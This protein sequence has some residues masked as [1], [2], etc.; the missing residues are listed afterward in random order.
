[1]DK[2]VWAINPENDTLD[3]LVTYVGKYVQDF[4]T[5]A[6]LR[7]RLDLPPELPDI[8]ISAEIR[9]NLFLAIKEAL[10]NAVKHAFAQELLF[11]LQ[12]QNDAFT[13]IIKDDGVGF[14]PAAST[15]RRQ[16][17]SRT[18]SGYGLDNLPHR[19]EAI[20]GTCVINSKSGQGT[21]IEL[22]ISFIKLTPNN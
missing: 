18:L 16:S 3:G 17:S 21:R 6:K 7:C 13:F 8:M 4:L 12:L 9:H 2:T 11:Q 14:I 15:A 10:N 19:L 22:S 1:M 5:A 20:G